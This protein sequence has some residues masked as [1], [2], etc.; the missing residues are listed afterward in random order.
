MYLKLILL[1]ILMSDKWLTKYKPKNIKEIIGNSTDILKINYW[2]KSFHDK[3][4]NYSTIIITSYHGIGKNMI[5]E[6]LLEKN[7]Y[8]SQ[9]LKFKDNKNKNIF[10]N[11]KNNISRI[12]NRN[13]FIK[14]NKNYSLILDDFDKIT[15]KR[16]KDII[17]ELIKNNNI[18][19][20]FPIILISNLSHSKLIKET[21]NRYVIKYKFIKP[22]KKDIFVFLNKILENEKINII[23]E[24]I[25]KIIIKYTSYDIRK[26]IITLYDIKR[27]FNFDL[28][29][30]DLF[31]QYLDNS[32]KKN[33]NIE[34]FDAT[35]MLINNYNGIDKSEYYYNIDKVLVP[36]TIYENYYKIINHK[37]KKNTNIIINLLKNVTSSISKGDII[38]TNIYTDQNWHFHK[39]HGFNSCIKTSYYI[40]KINSQS[41]KLKYKIDF[42]SDLNQTSLKN[43]N[44]KNIFTLKKIFKNKKNNYDII[45]I[46]KIVYDYI[47]NDKYDK[48]KEFIDEYNINIKTFINFLK[49]NKIQQK[50]DINTK[51]LKKLKNILKQ[52]SK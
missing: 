24:N 20:F 26:L 2:L 8:Y 5:I 50:L 3:K 40:N 46:N 18:N 30:E 33:K 22:S 15:L 13:Y 25:K 6:L 14:D 41:K 28:I 16:E 38:E 1:I 9:I 4:H 42:S 37:Y 44:K 36:L 35:K 21:L 48:I 45:Y 19:K 27:T 12:K 34:L 32:K 39:I 7:N 52:I 11:I 47:L 31:N 43:I 49:I 29:T 10:E 23:S 51:Y 17:I